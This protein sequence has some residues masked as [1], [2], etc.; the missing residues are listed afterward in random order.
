MLRRSAR[1][2]QSSS[3]EKKKYASAFSLAGHAPSGD[4]V[5]RVRDLVA[6]VGELALGDELLEILGHLALVEREA[7]RVAFLVD[8]EHRLEA[9]APLVGVDQRLGAFG[10]EYLGGK[11]EVE[12]GLLERGVAGIAQ[13]R[14]AVEEVRAGR[15]RGGCDPG[16]ERERQCQ[17]SAQATGVDGL[18]AL[19]QGFSK[20]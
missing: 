12:P 5:A 1:S 7:R 6:L 4:E 2:S 18:G 8:E 20:R 19:H 13:A 10:R 16:G 17:A 11:H 3:S 14:L 9:A 15:E